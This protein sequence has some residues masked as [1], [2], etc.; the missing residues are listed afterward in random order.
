MCG[1]SGVINFS[2]IKQD[3]KIALKKINDAIA[4]R[5]PDDGSF[6]FDKIVGLGHRRLSIVDLSATANQPMTSELEDVVI[7]NPLPIEVLNIEGDREICLGAS[8]T[9]TAQVDALSLSECPEGITYLWSTGETTQSI[10][11]STTADTEYTVV[12]SSCDGCSDE[13]TDMESIKEDPSAR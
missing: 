10:E 11:V 5:G 8:T 13:D 9:L 2:G 3:N 4:H 1:I 7:E 6:Y 12:A